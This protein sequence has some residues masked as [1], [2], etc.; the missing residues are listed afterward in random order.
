MNIVGVDVQV[1]WRD[2]GLGLG[3]AEPELNAIEVDFD[4]SQLRIRRVFTGWENGATSE[5]SWKTLAEVL[6][7]PLVKKQG[8]LADIHAKLRKKINTNIMGVCV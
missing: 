2:I 7:S 8:L 4:S 6:C 3:I 5:F 1:C